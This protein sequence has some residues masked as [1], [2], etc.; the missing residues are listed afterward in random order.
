MNDPDIDVTE[1]RLM[2]EKLARAGR[3]ILPTWVDYRKLPGL[4]RHG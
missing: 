2:Q 4:D 1:Q 3:Q